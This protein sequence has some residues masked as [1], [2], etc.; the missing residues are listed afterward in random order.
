MQPILIHLVNKE[1]SDLYNGNFRRRRP[2]RP[3]GRITVGHTNTALHLGLRIVGEH[4]SID[5]WVYQRP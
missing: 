4:G 2:Y 1:I 5:R 3:A